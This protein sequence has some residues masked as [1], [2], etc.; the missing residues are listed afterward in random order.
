MIWG[1]GE[2]KKNN[3]NTEKMVTNMSSEGFP[4][5]AV[6]ELGL[7]DEQY[8]FWEEKCKS[9]ALMGKRCWEQKRTWKKR[10]M[11]AIKHRSKNIFVKGYFG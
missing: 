6:S 4:E 11:V 3:E 8:F 10:D 2:E 1:F 9:F 5:E 7:K